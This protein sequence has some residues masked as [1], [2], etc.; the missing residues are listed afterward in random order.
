MPKTR[1]EK[2]IIINKSFK[3]SK[4]EFNSMSEEN[5]ETYYLLTYKQDRQTNL[6]LVDKTGKRVINNIYKKEEIFWG[7]HSE[8]CPDLY[9]GFH[10]GYR[11]SWQTALGAVPEDLIED[12][13]KK[14]SGS[15]LYDPALIPGILFTNEKIKRDDT[16]IYDIAPTVLRLAG[17][18]EEAISEGDFD[19][20]SLF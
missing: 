1:S 9:I 6:F 17:F 3:K 5:T 2:R 7:E 18:D 10:S 4:Q 8:L 12:N 11:A 14:W 19:G 20:K 16:S 13:M 15:H